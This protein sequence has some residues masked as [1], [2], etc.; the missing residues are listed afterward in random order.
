MCDP[1]QQRLGGE[2]LDAS[3]ML[4]G[5]SSGSACAMAAACQAGRRLPQRAV[6]GVCRR[7]LRGTPCRGRL[8]LHGRRHCHAGAA[9]LRARVRAIVTAM[10]SWPAL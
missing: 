5:Y 7:A 1:V 9:G 3:Q 2:L 10:K 6:A 4:A 8:V